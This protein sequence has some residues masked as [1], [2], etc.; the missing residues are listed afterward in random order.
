MSEQRPEATWR[1]LIVPDR[2]VLVVATLFCFGSVSFLGWGWLLSRQHAAIQAI[3]I[4][5]DGGQLSLL[6]RSH[7]MPE[8]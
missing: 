8:V 3:L 1:D 5:A 6:V 2:I 4:V 7:G